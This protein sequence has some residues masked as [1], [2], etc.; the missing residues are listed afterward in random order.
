[1]GTL[2]DAT[3]RAVAWEL[4]KHLNQV[5]AFSPS[6]CKKPPKCKTARL[7]LF[8]RCNSI[9]ITNIKKKLLS[10]IKSKHNKNAIQLGFLPSQK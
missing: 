10:L 2:L 3:F 5:G 9:P 4:S 8:K 6:N 7:V 1:M